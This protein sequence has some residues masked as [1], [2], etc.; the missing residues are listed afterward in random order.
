MRAQGREVIVLLGEQLIGKP[1]DARSRQVQGFKRRAPARRMRDRVHNRPQIPG[2]YGAKRRM[3]EDGR[4]IRD[5]CAAAVEGP[6]GSQPGQRLKIGDR[7]VA[8]VKGLEGG[9]PGKGRKVGDS[10]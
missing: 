4:E 2:A 1:A 5:L 3:R 6:E 10:C 9:K 8:A 7:C